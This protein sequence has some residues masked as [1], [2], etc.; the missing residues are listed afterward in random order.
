MDDADRERL[1]EEIGKMFNDAA[2][3]DFDFYTTEAPEAVTLTWEDLLATIEDIRTRQHVGWQFLFEWPFC[4]EC[5]Q[6]MP[7]HRHT[8]D[9][10]ESDA[11]RRVVVQMPPSEAEK[12]LGVAAG[13]SREELKSAY[14]KRLKETH[15]DT[16]GDPE[17]CRRVISAYE[18]LHKA[19]RVE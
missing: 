16:G 12:V 17:E 11:Y 5:A 3:S 6:Y 7:P 9:S 1:S 4:P 13:A 14:R 10:S 19:G 8:G 15:P 2:N 18:S